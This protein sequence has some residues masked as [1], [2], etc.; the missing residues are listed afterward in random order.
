MSLIEVRGASYKYRT[1]SAVS[2]LNLKVDQGSFV[3]V[4]GPSGSGK[5]T[6]A[7]L[8]NAIL[9]PQAGEVVID[10]SSTSDEG[11]LFRIRRT[12]GL[13][14][15]NPDN[16]IV[17]DTVEDDVAFSLENLGMESQ[18][19]EIII[20][21]VLSKVGLSDCRDASPHSLSGGQKQLL[22]IAGV[23]AMGPKC[24]VL[25]E[26]LSMLDTESRRAVLSLL[27]RLNREEGLTVILMSHSFE[28]SLESDLVHVMEGGRIVH[29]GEPEE[30][31]KALGGTPNF[32]TALASELRSRGMDIPGDIVTEQALA[33]FLCKGGLKC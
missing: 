31:I 29:S 18:K 9:V 11:K 1:I 7:R 25:D 4:I 12:V 20:S 28:D 30:V 21:E 27:H 26:A 16:Q 17:G 33:S 5:S 2:K 10:G 6:L 3:T 15:Q 14:L 23:L 22:A 13:V 32:A 19:M 24:L 8:L